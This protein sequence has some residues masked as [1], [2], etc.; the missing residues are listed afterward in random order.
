MKYKIV[1]RNIIQMG[2]QEKMMKSL[3]V[4]VVEF[5]KQNT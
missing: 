3:E 4:L 2:I 5:L 1:Q